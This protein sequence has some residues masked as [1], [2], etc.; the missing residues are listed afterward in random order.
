MSSRAFSGSTMRPPAPLHYKCRETAEGDGASAGDHTADRHKLEGQ[1]AQ[2]AAALDVDGRSPEPENVVE[3]H[4]S[5]AGDRENRREE[6]RA[7]TAG[8]VHAATQQEERSQAQSGVDERRE[9]RA[10]PSVIPHPQLVRQRVANSTEARL[11]E[12]AS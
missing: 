9:R 3:R 7:V 1:T 12:E 8:Q 10:E 11:T 5:R 6:R 2:E 4:E